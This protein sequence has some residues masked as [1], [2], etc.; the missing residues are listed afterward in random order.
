MLYPYRP[1]RANIKGLIVGL[2]LIV[3]PAAALLTIGPQRRHAAILKRAL[4]AGQAAYATRDWSTAY[5]Q[6]QEYLNLSPDNVEVLKKY[7]HARL[8][9][10]PFEPAAIYQAGSAYQQVLQ[11]EPHDAST[12]DELAK[13]H[14]AVRN[15]HGLAHVALQHLEHYPDDKTSP[16][17]LAEALIFQENPEA[18]HVILEPYI[19]ELEA[20]PDKHNEYVHAYL[21]MSRVAGTE[22]T[23]EAKLQALKWLNRAIAYAPESVEALVQRAQFHIDNPSLAS[24]DNT[25]AFKR[26]RQDLEAADTLGTNNPQLRLSLGK[27][28]MSL[29]EFDRAEA[30]LQ[31]VE[32]LDPAQLEEH[33]LD[34][35]D[36]HISR[37]FFA[38]ELALHRGARTEAASLT[39]EALGTLERSG[40]RMRVLPSSINVY[41]AAGRIPDARQC[42]EEYEEALDVHHGT[43]LLG[44]TLAKVQAQVIQ[45]EA[46]L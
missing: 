23:A 21:L 24:M 40:H 33:Y 25:S 6:F 36:W 42:L 39:D 19:S 43:R 26:V 13:L 37:Y 29:D 5:E 27:I 44:T 8:R 17:W 34:P 9:M 35:K 14:R 10:R 22:E 3:A 30:E 31:A 1:A 11:L 16:L 38:S 45:A 7:A 32:R 46:K 4:S 28:W 2:L 12:Y 41:L 18:A 15:F 20:V